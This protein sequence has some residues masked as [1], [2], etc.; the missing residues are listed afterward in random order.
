VL[1]H[2]WS[3]S[4]WSRILRKTLCAHHSS[5]LES[6][7]DDSL[8]HRTGDWLESACDNPL[9]HR[10]GDWLESAC[11]NPLNHRTGDCGLG[12]LGLE[13]SLNTCL[14]LSA[15]YCQTASHQMPSTIT[16]LSLSIL[17]YSNTNLSDPGSVLPSNRT[18]HMITAG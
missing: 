9:N 12:R 6:A 13:I 2:L 5:W 10:T 11:D 14:L 7:C 16:L 1:S 4:T 15:Y 3:W 18:V 8:N 17:S